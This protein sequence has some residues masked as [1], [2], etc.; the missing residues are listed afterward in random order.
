MFDFVCS[1]KHFNTIVIRISSVKNIARIER[2]VKCKE[3][4]KKFQLL[5][6]SKSQ[7]P[8]EAKDYIQVFGLLHG[9]RQKFPSYANISLKEV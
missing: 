3:C 7:N 8:I 9:I 5:I 4:N 6:E 1:G 2:V